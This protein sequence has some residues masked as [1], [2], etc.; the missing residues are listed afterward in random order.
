MLKYFADLKVQHYPFEIFMLLQP[1]KVWIHSLWNSFS[2]Y[3]FNKTQCLY[4]MNRSFPQDKLCSYLFLHLLVLCSRFLL[5]SFLICKKWKK[6]KTTLS[7]R[8]SNT[9]GLSQLEM[10]LSFHKLYFTNFPPVKFPSITTH[11][12]AIYCWIHSLRNI[13]NKQPDYF[14]LKWT[15]QLIPHF[16]I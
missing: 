8:S 6:S 2:Y 15:Y 14:N 10:H 9:K 5:R 7:Q 4:L 13:S 12:M 16:S 11:F 1:R 3:L